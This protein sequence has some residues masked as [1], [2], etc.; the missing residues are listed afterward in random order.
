MKKAMAVLAPVLLLST[1][2]Y[3][4]R[5]KYFEAPAGGQ[6]AALWAMRTNR[7]T[8]ETDR[9]EAFSGWIVVQTHSQWKAEQWNATHPLPAPVPAPDKQ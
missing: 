5:Y 8:N 3:L 2:L 6:Q 1:V 4:T 7:W 9:L